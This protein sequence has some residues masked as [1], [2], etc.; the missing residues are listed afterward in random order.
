MSTQGALTPLPSSSSSKPRWKYEVF[1]SFKGE[2]TRRSFTDHLY[3]ALK[4]KGIL[5]FRDDE[6]LERGKSISEE[7]LKAI[8]ESRFAI[9]IF[10]ENYASSRWCLD[11]LVHI[12]R[13]KKEIGLEVVLVFYHVN[14]SDVRHQGGTFAQ[15][16]DKHKECFK[17]SIEKVETWRAALREVANL[18]GWDLQ[19]RHESEFIQYIVK[20]MMEKLSSE[21]SS[22]TKNLVGI[23]STMAKLIPLYLG[24]GNRVYMLGICGMGGLGKTTLARTIYYRYSK[25]FEGSSFIL[26]VR[27]RSKEGSLLEF[28]Q[29]LLDQILGESD[30]KIWDVYHGV[31]TIKR[32][33]CQKK[34]LLVL[35]DVNQMYQLQKLAREDGWFG[36]GSWII[37]T[38]RDKQVLVGHRVHQIYELNGLNNYDASKLFCLH[39]FK[40]ELPKK[41][42]MQL[43][44]EVLEYAKGL[45]LALVTLGS[46]L[47]ERRID[48]WQSALNNFKKTEG[49]IFGILKISYDGLEEIWKEIFLDIA[50]F[51]RQRKKDEV[52][53]ILKNCGFDA[54]IVISVLVER[55]LLTMDDNECLGMHDLLTEMGQKI[56]LFESSRNLGKHSR[57]W[58]IE[59]LLHVLENDMATEAI[60]AIVVTQGEE[61]INFEEFPEGF[62]K[63]SNLRLLI[64]KPN[65]L[66]K[67]KL[68]I[69]NALDHVPSDQRHLALPNNLRHL[70]WNYCPFKCL[71]SSGKRKAFVH[72]DLQYSKFEFLW[73]GVMV[74]AKLKFIDLS[75]SENLIRIPDFS[76]VPILEELNLSWCCSLVEIHPSIGQL[77]SLSMI[78]KFTGIMKSLSELY[79]GM[80]DIKKVAP[81]S[82]E[83]LAALTLLDLS[84]CTNLK[85]LPSNMDNLRSLEMLNLFDCSKLKYL[86]RLPSTLTY[87]NAE[88]CS[89][90]K[91]L[92]R[93]PSTLRYLNVRYCYSLKWSPTWVKLSSWSQLLSW[94]R[95]YGESGS[96]VEFTILF[97]FL[98]GLLCYKTVNGTSSKTEFQIIVPSW[99][100]HQSVGNSISIELP[101]NWCN[102]KW[103]GFALWA[104]LSGIIGLKHG[105]RVRVIALGDMPQNHCASELFTTWTHCGVSICLLYLF[106]DD[107][108]TKVGE[109]SHIKVIFETNE[110]NIYVWK[111]GV[112]LV[113]EQDVDEFNQTNAQCLIESVGEVFI[114][115]LSVGDNDDDDIHTIGDDND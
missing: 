19:D 115:K 48:E 108:V 47:V 45:P 110:S 6:K 34:V 73:E 29:Q 75:H 59:D 92:L 8:E 43:S 98:E 72:L 35:D 102:S 69:L 53:Q 46:F 105:I 64:I 7:L 17:E 26:N 111:C 44:Q 96:R 77:S 65:S 112:S 113:Y 93:L 22:F 101:S 28:Q 27:E 61:E 94:W 70:S 104:S 30:T 71:A 103:M 80:T 37:I 86:P 81:S 89:S 83:C 87:I 62:S 31:D 85:C 24:F 68:G 57:L 60:Q 51:F 38:T 32:R 9:I 4:K 14:P 109:C 40:M 58:L 1:L 42:Y 55:Y 41:D 11:E 107:W 76:G 100:T 18:S 82:V 114:F 12:I 106:H 5:T 97:H 84:S 67:K 50:C 78:P 54:T 23:E 13:C 15:A 21:F 49:G 16:F 36:L 25:Y 88:A 79:L 99:L 95:L 33:L 56:I 10:S 66:K 2:D 52:I 74:L 39:A 90:L 91:S 3:D 20:N 63:M